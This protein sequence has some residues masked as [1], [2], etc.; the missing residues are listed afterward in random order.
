MMHISPSPCTVHI[1][2]I[3]AEK[4]KKKKKKKKNPASLSSSLT[5][6][7]L[8]ILLVPVGERARSSADDEF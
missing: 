5:Y 2:H 1:R 6:F 8:W 4:K 7:P 3:A